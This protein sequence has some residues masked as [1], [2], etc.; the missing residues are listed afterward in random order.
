MVCS[1]LTRALAGLSV[2]LLAALPAEE[3]ASKR[4]ADF[5]KKPVF[6]VGGKKGPP[7]V[8]ISR[9]TASQ[10]Q[11]SLRFE[12][13][14]GPGRDR[15]WIAFPVKEAKG[16]NAIAFDIYCEQYHQSWLEAR[17]TQ[18]AV[19]KNKGAT[20]YARLELGPFTD[21]WTPVCLAQAAG[22]TTVL[23]GSGSKPD[24]SQIFEIRFRLHRGGKTILYLDNLRFQKVSGT[25]QTRNMLYNSSF[26]KATNPDI[27]DGWGRDLSVPPFGEKVWGLDRKTAFYGEKS[28]RIGVPGKWARYWLRHLRSSGGQIYTFS[29]YLKSDQE[30]T[31]VRLR[32]Y[33]VKDGEQEVTVDEEWERYSVTAV[34]AGGG[35]YA[36]VELLSGGVLWVDAAQLEPGTEPTPYAPADLDRVQPDK[37]SIKGKQLSGLKVDPPKATVLPTQ[38]PPVLDGD[39]SDACWPEAQE[40]T[41]FKQLSKDEPARLKTVARVSYD[42]RAF[43]FAVHAS[44]PDMSGVH[45]TLAKVKNGPWGT[46]CVEFFIDLNHDRSTYYQFCANMRGEKWEA[47]ITT[48]DLFSGAASSWHCDWQAAGKILEDGWTVEAAIPFACL[49]W[50]PPMDLGE[51]VGINVCRSDPRKKEFT[52]WSCTYGAFH[53]PAAFGHVSGIDV[54]PQ[55]FRYEVLGVDWHRARAG[56]SIRNHTGEDQQVEAAFEA[57]GPDGQ[58][59]R[60]TDKGT[61]EA[62]GTWDATASLQLAGQGLHSLAVRLKD[63]DGLERLVSQPMDVRIAE[64]S[65]LELEGTEFDFYTREE[66]AR[67]RC[68]I[69][70]SD[71]RCVQMALNWWLERDGKDAAQRVE[72]QSKPGFNEWPVPLKELANGTYELRVALEE[73]GQPV[74]ESGKRFRKL[75]PAKHEVRINQWGRFLVFDGEPFLWYGFYDN[76]Y[77]KATPRER[78]PAALKD[79]RSV[80]ST[81]VMAYTYWEISKEDEIRW[82][83]DQAHALGMKVWVHLQWI[84]SY[85]NP[86]YA[87]RSQRYRS[88]EEAIGVL[89]SVIK[90]HRE[91]PALLGWSPLDE[92][93]NRPATFTKELTEKFYHLIKE[94]D[95]YHPCIFSHLTQTEHTEIYGEA[96][97]MALI[98]FG[99][100][101]DLR[102]DRLFHAFWGTGLPVATNGP[103]YG[104][105]SGPR[106][107]TAQEMRVKIYKPL[108]LGARGF[109]SYTYRGASMVTWREF[110]RIGEEL[111]TLAPI[112]LTPDNRL[113]VEVSPRGRDAFALL[114]EHEGAYYLIALN[115]LSEPLDASLRLVDVPK[116]SEVMPMFGAK[117]PR[118]DR[119]AKKLSVRMD[120]KSTA[121]YQIRP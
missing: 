70:A 65:L 60:A 34:A 14:E 16:F 68:F 100:G 85:C 108:I 13:T 18:R 31:K 66:Q 113:R 55:P 26:E 89:R 22:L 76:M 96:T 45:D 87:M 99:G 78:W 103:C 11:K 19:G 79:M 44:E 5:E 91:H 111:H 71:E 50:R 97:D 101:R 67:A 58:I 29:I 57:V 47:R 27:P 63:K 61:I 110:R 48:K 37:I 98:P 90:A 84:F 116:V 120:A 73:K 83:L 30:D 72:A 92:P 9:L 40:L 1:C 49:D 12:H 6:T 102:Y 54:N 56:A 38:K 82:A 115:V 28:L 25:G 36:T 74:A 46:D 20:Y 43:Y 3:P 118:V 114:K 93:G 42:D 32:M 8:E 105:I 121:V 88:E 77:K 2:G 80:H 23:H 10:G 41:P 64:G 52:S 33:G 119:E 59:H 51:T 75:P 15:G 81:A 86:K 39:L 62:G 4:I 106:E 7:K 17:L 53:T 95:P 69:D 21:G 109:S 104:A 94:L 112:L 24:W 35:L 117:T 107:P